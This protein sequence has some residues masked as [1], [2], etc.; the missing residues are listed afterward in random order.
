MSDQARRAR[1]VD[2]GKQTR[3]A[4]PS[5]SAVA[6]LVLLIGACGSPDRSFGA[7]H[8]ADAGSTGGVSGNGGTAQAG[9]GTGARAGEGGD[10]GDSGADG[11]ASGAGT[12]GAGGDAGLCSPACEPEAP[13][14][15]EGVCVECL[16]DSRR[17]VGDTPEACQAG[18]W[19]SL[20]PCPLEAPAC[21]NGVCA[22]ARVTGGL[23]T[24]Q[25][26]ATAGEIRLRDHGFEFQPRT[27]AEVAGAMM[28]VTGGLRP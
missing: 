2:A 1:G 10:S 11:G 15:V 27:C 8:Q 6:C 14:C 22:P 18:S 25:A 24:V 26:D 12:A 21:T 5:F 17:C 13:F 7:P 20:A 19:V 16:D 4:G 28:C 9:M 23:V 3:A